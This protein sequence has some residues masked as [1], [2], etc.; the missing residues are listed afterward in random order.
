LRA[1][2]SGSSFGSEAAFVSG[3]IRL[4]E[5][6]PRYDAKVFVAEDADG[7]TGGEGCR[8]NTDVVGAG[9]GVKEKAPELL[10]GA[11]NPENPP[12][13]DG[14][15]EGVIPFSGG[16]GDAVPPIDRLGMARIFLVANMDSSAFLKA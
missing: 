2:E 9:G 3:G 11:P 1:V 7:A 5:G 4:V 12:N 10:D 15:D 8:P 16:G 6:E 13:R 14:S